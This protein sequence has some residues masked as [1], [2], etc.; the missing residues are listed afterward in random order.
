[1]PTPTSTT[2]T[3]SINGIDSTHDS[4]GLEAARGGDR[5]AFDMLIAPFRDQLLAHCYRMLGSV[6]DADDALQDTMVRAWKG[7][8]GFDVR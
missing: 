2:S 8:S 4:V 3:T 7:L 1:M 6:H 5:E